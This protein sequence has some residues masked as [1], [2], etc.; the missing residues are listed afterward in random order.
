VR[1]RRPRVTGRCSLARHTG[2]S[3]GDRQ[4][5]IPARTLAA[6]HRPARRGGV[7]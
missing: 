3:R 2:L 4:G 7:L 1:S 6:R 5:R